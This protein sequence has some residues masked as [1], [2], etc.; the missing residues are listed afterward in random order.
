[1][2]T[3]SSCWRDIKGR[4]SAGFIEA[5]LETWMGLEINREKTR[6]VDLKQEGASLDFLGYTFRYDRDR[7]VA[8]SLPECGTVEEGAEAGA[9]EAARDDSTDVLQA[10]PEAD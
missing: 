9:G 2:P 5:K 6:V 10:N 8:T 7:Q 1:M 4:S 3:T